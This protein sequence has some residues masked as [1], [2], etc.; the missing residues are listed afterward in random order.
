[1]RSASVAAGVFAALATLG[2][3]ADAPAPAPP[4]LEAE[5]AWA[6]ASWPADFV[7]LHFHAPLAKLRAWVARG[8]VPV[9]LFNDD[10]ACRA[11]T[12]SPYEAWRGDVEAPDRKDVDAS[13]PRPMTAKIVGRSRVEDGR[14]L[15]EV[16]YVTVDL[17][18]SAEDGSAHEVRG[19]DGRWRLADSSGYG[20]PPTIYGALSS[21]DDR[22]ARWGGE[23][24]VIRPYCGGPVE[25]LACEGGGERQC[26]RCE[27]VAVMIVSPRS[28]S[29][30]SFSRGSRAET[31]HDPCPRY[32]E[33]AS[34]ERL[35][36]LSARVSLWRAQKQPLAAVPSLYKSRDDCLREHPQVDPARTR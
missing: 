36:A 23:T 22:V 15:R 1:M 7:G 10:F 20:V 14:T 13:A 26:V 34:I 2:A 29:G 5:I 19:Q 21:A 18:L 12:L 8:S 16:R 24:Q 11:A 33:S 9:Y 32:P 35:H 25:W 31:C 17:E 28:F 4:N 6:R 30:H 3:R 27:Q